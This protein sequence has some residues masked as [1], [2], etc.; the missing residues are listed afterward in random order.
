[1]GITQKFFFWVSYWSR[2]KSDGPPNKVREPWRHKCVCGW[3]CQWLSV[4]TAQMKSSASL[5]STLCVHLPAPTR[6]AIDLK[7]STPNGLF[8]NLEMFTSPEASLSDKRRCWSS[9]AL[10]FVP[11]HGEESSEWS[12]RAA[13][14]S[15]GAASDST[16]H[17]KTQ[18]SKAAASAQFNQ[19]SLMTELSSWITAANQPDSGLR[20]TSVVGGQALVTK[21]VSV[22]VLDLEA[23]NNVT[24]A[25][26][27]VFLLLFGCFTML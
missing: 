11:V 17:T 14:M 24:R 26:P 9:T 10:W 20:S 2:F 6:Q 25:V 8:L 16:K 3:L 5:T 23:E 22:C 21:Q 4:K 12:F 1:M 7:M 13:L 19:S 15:P 18:H 27:S